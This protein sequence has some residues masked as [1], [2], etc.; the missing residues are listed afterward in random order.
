[1]STGAGEAR[2]IEGGYRRY[3]GARSGVPGAIRSTTVNAIQRAL[4]LRRAARHKILPILAALLAFVPAIVFAGLSALLPADTVVGDDLL[5]SYAEYYL[6]ITAAI[7]VFCAFVAPEVLCTDRRTGMLGLYLASPLTRNTYLLSKGLS[8]LL[9]LAIVTLGPPLF[10]LIA[11]VLVGTGPEGPI[12]VLTEGLQIVGAGVVVSCFFASLSLAVSSITDRKA[13]ASASIVVIL[14][15]SSIVANVLVENADVTPYLLLADL[16]YLPFQTVFFIFGE[17]DS[18]QG[19]GGA[20]LY[21]EITAPVAYA[22]IAA[23]TVL[24][25][26]IVVARYR[27]LQVTR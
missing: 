14:L 3:D 20:P 22:A 4:G 13:A 5:P 19:E 23:W 2:I 7:L 25:S 26:A 1:M 10:L 8:V 11:F 6:F 21:D 9:V 16:F 27:R 24:F 12:D 18:S 17:A 15:L